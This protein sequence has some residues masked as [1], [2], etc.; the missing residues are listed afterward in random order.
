MPIFVRLTHIQA[1]RH[2]L[3]IALLAH[4]KP[5][6]RISSC[7][8]GAVSM[9]IQTIFPPYLRCVGRESALSCAF[10]PLGHI[11]KARSGIILFRVPG[12]AEIGRG[13][14]QPGLIWV[15]RLWPMLSYARRFQNLLVFLSIFFAAAA[16]RS[17]IARKRRISAAFPP[18]RRIL[19]ER[20]VGFRD[21]RA[22]GL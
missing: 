9:P 3:I 18:H 17:R 15:I 12:A 19:R 16:R 13:K 14:A 20:N 5:I 22:S 11:Y 2:R 8:Y 21:R 6:P 1:S 4:N 7:R 10:W